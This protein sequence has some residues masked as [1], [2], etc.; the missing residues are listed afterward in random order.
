MKRVYLDHNATTPLDARV[1]EAMKPYFTDAYGN[2]SSPH[3][4]GRI[5]KQ[6][7]EEARATVAEAIGAKP[8]EIIFTSG[9]TE[10]D[11]LALRG[12]AYH[13]ERGHII[14]ASIEHHAVLKTCKDLENDGFSVT[15]LSV[16]REGRVDPDEV[17]RSIRK[18]TILVSIMY[19][20]NETG[21]IEP[22]AE[23][24]RIAR[25]WGI[26]FHSDAV[27]ALGKIEVNVEKL[28]VDL[29]SLSA[30]KI[31]G[32]KGIGALFVK[33]GVRL[34]PLTTGGS[35]EL[36]MRAGTEN[37]PAIV[38]F[39]KALKIADGEIATYHTKVLRLRDKLESDLLN[40]LSQVT[41]HSAK[42]ERLPHT[43]CIGFASVE[44]ES[45]LLHL[46]LKGIAA[47]SGSACTTGEPEPSHVLL[48]MNVP[49]E[50]AQ[51][52]IRIS[53]GKENNEEE[54]DYTVDVLQ[55]VI[56]QL[57]TISSQ[58]A[59]EGNKRYNLT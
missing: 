27:Q 29:L 53:L 36:G 54:I 58:W 51:G 34:S 21:V 55:N 44:A 13:K 40:N 28:G 31:Y 7:L 15:Y 9:G 14:T 6:A 17:R 23:I 56:S 47:S 37:I 1:G 26:P 32:P 22:I 49:I 35:H 41:I 48:A 18:N 19:A 24:G 25:E 11:N 8:E 20:N 45:I 5:A 3:H 30:H 43:S 16:D 4:Y 57:R 2:P 46:D 38:G 42:A 39:A 10:S 59:V 12:I 52:S 33:D 50:L